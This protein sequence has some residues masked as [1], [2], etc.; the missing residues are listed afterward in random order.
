MFNIKNKLSICLNPMA[1]PNVSTGHYSPD[2]K[3][4]N[5]LIEIF[6]SSSRRDLRLAV[7]QLVYRL[8]QE[9][10]QDLRGMVVLVDSRISSEAVH[11]EMQ[12]FRS[13][14]RDDLFSRIDIFNGLPTLEKFDHEFD[15][16]QQ[17]QTTEFHTYLLNLIQQETA[18][19]RPYGS[20]PGGGKDAVLEFLIL[21]WLRSDGGLSTADVQRH[22]GVS[23]PT[24][25]AVI[26]DLESSGYIE[27]GFNRSVELKRFP[28]TEWRS[29]SARTITSRKTV[30]YQSTVRH[31]PT[32]ESWVLIRLKKLGRDDIAVGGTL[33]A[34]KHFPML[35]VVGTPRVDLVVLGEPRDMTEVD[36]ARLDPTLERCT[37]NEAQASLAV[38]FV[39]RRKTSRFLSDGDIL[40]ADPL[41]CIVDMYELGLESQANEMLRHL[42]DARS[43]SATTGMPT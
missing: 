8:S 35:D 33:G 43:K 17:L 34:A 20:A 25:A 15:A 39:G 27:R 28:W 26:K 1:N 19:S 30:L 31:L 29:W 22:V 7:L 38:H 42:V 6:T 37:G 9:S 18:P 4:A 41:T 13:V 3:W 14:L 12:M 5:W 2:G 24:A 11:T 21:S 32:A 16:P 40:Y 36:V 23:Y 10:S